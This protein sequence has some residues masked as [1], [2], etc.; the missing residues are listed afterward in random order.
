LD[1][2]ARA[3]AAAESQS[4]WDAEGTSRILRRA[5]SVHAN[6]EWTRLDTL[7]R[8]PEAAGAEVVYH[9][10]AIVRPL[11]S[12]GAVPPVSGPYIFCSARLA[13]YKG[14]DILVM[15]FAEVA[16]AHPGVSL[17]LCGEDMSGGDLLRFSAKLGLEGRVHWAGKLPHQRTLSLLR[18]CLFA[19]LPSRR[20]SLGV[21]A[22]E[23]LQAG[24]AIVATRAGGIPEVVRDGVD[25]LLVEPKDVGAL[26]AAMLRLLSEEALRE[27]MGRS[28]ARRSRRFSW[29]ETIDRYQQVYAA[30]RCSGVGAFRPKPCFLV[31]DFCADSSASSIARNAGAGFA[32]VGQPHVICVRRS[33]W[34]EPFRSGSGLSRVYRLGLPRGRARLADQGLILAQLFWIARKEAVDIWHYYL[35]RYRDLGPLIRFAEL[36]G[37]RPVV[38]LS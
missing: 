35:L 23:A 5:A 29:K 28:G 36:S 13:E 3:R 16:R 12:P 19:V 6:S 32:A 37:I 21:A 26:S 2:D 20:E 7:K 24:K 4:I 31:W 14:L 38:T 17:V 8:C 27:R 10:G 15:A 22:V 1:R 30:G 33:G 18:G 25:G 34:N 9:G 11:A